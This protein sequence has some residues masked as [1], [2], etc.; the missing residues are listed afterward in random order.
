MAHWHPLW[1][2]LAEKCSGAPGRHA[3]GSPGA[4]F[5]HNGGPWAITEA[6]YGSVGHP[7]FLK[8]LQDS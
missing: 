8:K 1:P 3:P 7:D 6:R 5:G 4:L 2:V